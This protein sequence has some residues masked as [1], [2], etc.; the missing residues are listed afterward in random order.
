LNLSTEFGGSY[1][2]Q[3]RAF[4]KSVRGKAQHATS[5]SVL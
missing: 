3:S 2:N 1:L 5:S 4:P